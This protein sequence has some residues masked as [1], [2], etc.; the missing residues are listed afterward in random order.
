MNSMSTWPSILF[1]ILSFWWK[2]VGHMLFGHPGQKWIQLQACF[3]GKCHLWVGNMEVNINSLT[4]LKIS[5]ASISYIYLSTE[6]QLAEIA[7][8]L[9]W[10]KKSYLRSW[11]GLTHGQREKCRVVDRGER[12][13][14]QELEKMNRE[15]SKHV[16]LAIPRINHRPIAQ[17][18]KLVIC[19]TPSACR[20]CCCNHALLGL[21]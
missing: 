18:V 10:S 8:A 13:L 5:I 14:A 2:L 3:S 6:T 16:L 9:V 11:S 12:E 4:L 20:D 1:F 15:F 21:I 17:Q 7:W 19:A